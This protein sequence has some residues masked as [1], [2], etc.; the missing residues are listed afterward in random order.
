MQ[1][2]PIYTNDLYLAH[3][4]GTHHPEHPERLRSCLRALRSDDALKDAIDWREGRA[5]TDEEILRCHTKEHL[6]RVESA[7]GEAGGFDTDT[8][9]SEHSVEAARWAAGSVV[10]AVERCWRGEIPTAF[11]LARPPGHH[12]TPNRAMGFCLFNNV[13]IAARHLRALGCERVLIADWDVHHGNGTQDIF[14][15]DAS[16]FYYSLHQSPHYPGTGAA[17]EIGIR[18]GEGATLNRP[19]PA[20]YPAAEF[21]ELFRCDLT[22]I[23]ES[24]SPEFIIISA[25][26]DSHRDDPLGD[27][28]LDDGDYATMT[29]IAADLVA[30]GHV[31]GV[32]E[33]GYNVDA[34]A[35]SV[36]R[37]VR[38]LH[39]AFSDDARSC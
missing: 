18:E 38:T 33:G 28:L 15:E 3:D 9:F 8:R 25:G 4:T 19:L 21:V 20:R 39:A 11:S 24:F 7:R 32:L 23:A 29:Q 2:M 10:D 16:V 22:A 27:L 37:H 34:L 36:V 26:F 31:I 12:A 35:H 17:S 13:A 30:P 14:W 6:E 1:R 5:A